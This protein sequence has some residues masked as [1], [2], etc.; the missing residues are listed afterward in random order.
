MEAGNTSV[1]R[2]PNEIIEKLEALLF[3]VFCL[4]RPSEI[5]A[6]FVATPKWQNV[7]ISYLFMTSI[8]ALK[9]NVQY[10]LYDARF[11]CYT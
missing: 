8:S 1:Q 4:C 9:K 10:C 2:L 11:E 3:A 6:R 7:Y 5:E